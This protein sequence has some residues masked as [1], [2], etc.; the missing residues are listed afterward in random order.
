M[1]VL[2]LSHEGWRVA[3]AAWSAAS[4]TRDEVEL[5]YQWGADGVSLLSG[6]TGIRRVTLPISMTEFL[7]RISQAGTHPIVD[8]QS[9]GDLA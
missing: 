5:C 1:T 9:L 6:A 8:L 4:K 3:T 2:L 7:G